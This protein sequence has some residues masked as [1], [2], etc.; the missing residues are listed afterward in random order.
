MTDQ[1][2]GRLASCESC[3]AGPIKV[4]LQISNRLLRDAL[5]RL[6]GKSKDLLVMDLN[7]KTESADPSASEEAF[8]V[9][10]AD[11]F[12]PKH[13]RNTANRS[14]VPDRE[15]KFIL[16]G[17]NDDPDKF[18]SAIRAGVAGY[19]MNDASPT[20]IVTAVLAPFRGEAY[21]PPRLCLAMFRHIATQELPPPRL[22]QVST[23]DLTLRQERLIDLVA[24][25]L[26]N[27]E[28]ARSLNLSEFTVRNHIHRILRKLQ[29]GSRKEAVNALR[30]AQRQEFSVRRSP[31]NRAESRQ[32]Q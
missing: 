4:Q 32:A 13:F 11:T 5:I 10:I 31:I 15:V 16:I 3:N 30:L 26:T 22:E 2:S 12:D 19:L 6:L 28:I 7:R 24:K 1:L 21:C 18:L 14:E 27:K 25:G 29:A 23:A 20:D 17:M 9:M 8:D